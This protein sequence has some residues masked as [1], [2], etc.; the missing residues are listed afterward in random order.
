MPN[1]K[2]SNPSFFPAFIKVK[3]KTSNNNIIKNPGWSIDSKPI[4]IK[5]ATGKKGGKRKTRKSRKSKKTKKGR[6]TRKNKI[7]KGGDSTSI[8]VGKF[9]PFKN[10]I[11]DKCGIC[12]DDL[13]NS[14]IIMDKGIVY[15][16]VCGHQFHSN[17]LNGRCAINTKRA[18]ADYI[19]DNDEE[20]RRPPANFKCPV[21]NQT[22][23]NE[24][25]DC[26][27]VDAYEDGYLF[28][29]DKYTSEEYTGIKKTGFSRFFKR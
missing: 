25:N 15:Q 7:N 6:K 27:S 16:L 8:K 13:Q 2:I 17:C 18:K 1:K 4:V 28:D 12:K 5:R 22:T 23:L 21:C 3:A 29:K 10:I 14:D 11:N 24:E 19:K 9:V 26:I 20:Y